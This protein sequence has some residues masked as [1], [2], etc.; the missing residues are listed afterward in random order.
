LIKQILILLLS[1]G[2]LFC[3]TSTPQQIEVDYDF[4]QF[5]G[6]ESQTIVE[7]YYAISRSSLMHVPSDNGFMGGYKITLN[8]SQAGSIVGTID[9][10]GGDKVNTLEEIT[11]GQTISDVKT[12]L[13]KPAA[14]TFQLV[15]LDL[16]NSSENTKLQNITIQ[17]F[18]VGNQ[19]ISAIQFSHQIQKAESANRFVKN[20]YQITPNP[21][22]VYNTN[23]PIL[24][25]Y[26]EV[27]HLDSFDD[28]A[29]FSLLSSIIGQKGEVVKN[30][31]AKKYNDVDESIVVIGN[32]YVGALFTGIYSLNIELVNSDTQDT[33]RQN[34]QFYVFRPADQITLAR[35]KSDVNNKANTYAFMSE[36]EIDIEFAYLKYLLSDDE[37]DRYEELNLAAKREYI[38]IYWTEKEAAAPGFKRELYDRIEFANARYTI[39]GKD[40]WKTQPGRVLMMYGIPDDIEKQ[41]SVSTITNY[42]VWQ[43]QGVEGGAMFVFVNTS[44]Y[45]EL[46]MVHSTVMDEIKDY[47]WQQNY[48]R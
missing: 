40:G 2:T 16:N 15:I 33:L 4:A 12:L 20:G 6:S 19:S 9:W 46:R 24:F 42:E 14:Y 32:V 41:R 25:Y 29:E 3:Q 18:T 27:Y 38:N 10:Q 36:E 35:N 1:A 11:T 5:R 8:I 28:D 7:I 31:P 13:F 45:G 44:G 21:T 39:G 43:Y 34:K 48:L 47:Q 23:Q 22:V 17:E 30:L 26:L 37:Q